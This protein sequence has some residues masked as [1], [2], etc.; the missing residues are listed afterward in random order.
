MDEKKIERKMEFIIEQ[1]AQF[2]VDIQLL[3]E[4]QAE[5]VKTQA[6]I[7]KSH[8]EMIKAQERGEDRMT[9]MEDVV[10]RL[11]GVV[12][13]VVEVQGQTM[14]TVTETDERLNNLITIVE[15]FISESRNGKTGQ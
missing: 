9:R 4:S 10:L 6:E 8:S 7:I 11:A 13:K 1:Q 3:R 2:A 12:E 14:K 5:L 15:R